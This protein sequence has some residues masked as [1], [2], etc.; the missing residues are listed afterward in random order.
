MKSLKIFVLLVIVFSV[1]CNKEKESKVT[2]IMDRTAG[3]K[4][5]LA[6]KELQ[7]YIYL[8]CGTL[9][10]ISTD[11]T[12]DGNTIVLKKET[13]LND[14]QYRF[15][16]EGKTLTISGG[17]DVALLYGAYTFIEKLGIQFQLDRDV[18]PDQ[19]VPFK[20]PGLNET[21]KPL[22]E[23][24]GILPFHDFPQGPDWWSTDDY[25]RYIT[26][27]ARM[28]MNFIGFHN[29]P[30]Q[31]EKGMEPLVWIG[32]DSDFDIST[33][34]VNKSYNTYW[35]NTGISGWNHARMNTSEF[36]AGVNQLFDKEEYGHPAF[37][38]I[39]KSGQSQEQSNKV[40]NRVGAMLNSAFSHARNVG[41][42][43]CIG[44]QT[45][46][47]SPSAGT[48]GL[49]KKEIYMGVFSRIKAT[50]SLDYYWL[51]MSEG[52]TLHGSSPEDFQQTVSDIKAAQETLQELG[53]PFKLATCGW[54][55]GPLNDRAA[56][57]KV[58]SKDVTLS[59]IN[60]NVGHQSVDASYGTIK[61]RPLW[62]I[63]WLENDPNMVGPQPWVGRM[64][65][66]AADALHFGC[67]G[68]IGIHWRTRAMSMNIPALAQ[69]GWD[70]SWSDGI[71][72]DKRE[73]WGSIGGSIVKTNMA[74]FVYSKVRMGMSAHHFAIPNG[75]Y[76]VT[77]MFCEP[78]YSESGKRIFDVSI[79]NKKV[80]NKLDIFSRIGEN[81]PLELRF[82][83]INI[84]NGCLQ[85]DY[86]A[87]KDYACI[88][89]IQIH[90][91]R[92]A[93]NG[94]P[95]APYRRY[96]NCAGYT[97]FEYGAGDLAITG[98]GRPRSEPVIDF[99]TAW[100]SARFGEAVGEKIAN[101]MSSVDGVEFPEISFWNGPG[102]L[103]PCTIPWNEEKRRFFFVEQ[104]EK[105]RPE[106]IGAGNL[107]RFDYWLNTY[108]FTQAAARWNCA[109]GLLGEM[110][111]QMKGNPTPERKAALKQQALDTR[112]Q[113]SRLWEELLGY[114][115][116]T[117]STP[118][119][120]ATLANLEQLT[121]KHLNSLTRYDMELKKILRVETLPAEVVL[122]KEY[123]GPNCILVPT[124]RS[125][126]N[127]HE[128][129]KISVLLPS[130]DGVEKAMLF[131]R[132]MGSSGDWTKI[133]LKHNARAVY[134]A[135]LPLA[136][137][138]VEYYV[139]SKF[140]DAKILVWPVTAP[141]INHTIVVH[142]YN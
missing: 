123:N 22:F 24:R 137:K 106:V 36:V 85:I 35:A 94:F 135:E 7:R 44:T 72:P 19:Q 95:A 12:K 20:L 122:R 13:E 17:S 99:Y 58:L 104:L 131:Y 88:A 74:G 52:W 82:E 132:P 121:R 8:R 41:V 100:T 51:W 140:Q 130:Q 30:P 128:L 38:G 48:Q 6:A 53:N 138:S 90:G 91:I 70:Q 77:L 25:H 129:L 98:G 15:L 5:N 87:V 120:L 126:A 50:H 89:G 113:M 133:P 107:D 66:D 119:D 81:H 97:Y 142:N 73:K 46:L 109:V 69:A 42:K 55:L 112:I 127:A 31:G 3:V 29:Y 56:L 2:I 60:R 134:T 101:I 108:R 139:K 141:Y 125:L 1:A 23:T 11:F 79:Q 103:L 83:N 92:D 57:D 21:Y 75:K 4:E 76:S 34:K 64:R 93:H 80:I 54:V 110:L 78:N 32:N 124:Q 114:L 84:S 118:G 115:I 45:P 28:R 9:P 59:S 111:T 27:L 96:I 18:I 39:P 136:A 105:L 117:V 62:A 14:Q 65:R 71:S 67:K 37:D 86:H 49:S 63:P 16:T 43:T 102:A 10:L 116:P 40:F 47:H 26:G 61:D 68:L 33:G